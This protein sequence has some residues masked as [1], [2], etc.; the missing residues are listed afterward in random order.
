MHANI[1]ATSMCVPTL[2]IAYSHKSYGIM[3]ILGMEK[4]VL[5]FRTMTFGEM[6]FGIDDLWRDR[7]KI[8]VEL[9]SNVE[10]IKHRALQNGKLVKNLIDSLNNTK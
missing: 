3:R 6:T 5:D 2:A 9:R 1:A 8:K 10:I 7:E 4:Y